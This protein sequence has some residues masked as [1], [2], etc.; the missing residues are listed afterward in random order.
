MAISKIPGAG[1]S[2]DT[3]E[4]GDI[5]D[6][7]IG[8]A[9]LANDVTISTS[10]NI[11][12]T[13]S[14][15]LSVAGTSTLTGNVTAAGTH[16][17]TGNAT[18][19]GTLGVTGNA[20]ASGNLTVTGDIIPS[21]PLSHRNMI[22]NGGMQIFQRATGATTATT[23]YDTADR[24]RLYDPSSGSYTSEKHTMS[25]AEL[26]T[27]GQ[28]H[29]LKLACTGVSSAGSGDHAYF[30]QPLEG[31]DCQRLLYGTANAKTVTLSFWVKSTITGTYCVSVYVDAASNYQVAKEYTISSADTWEKKTITIT[32]TEGSTSLIT[33]SGALFDDN[34]SQAFLL[35]FFL[36]S[37]SSIE[38]AANEWGTGG[39][40]YSTSGQVNWLSSTSNRFYI[41]GIQLEEGSSATPFEYR[42]FGEELTR[43]ERYHQRS[44]G[45]DWFA[46]GYNIKSNDNKRVLTSHD[47]KTEMRAT[48]T[49]TIS[50][51]GTAG[52]TFFDNWGVGNT[53]T[54]DG[55]YA[56]WRTRKHFTTGWTGTE[57]ANQP[58]NLIS[59][60][61]VADIEL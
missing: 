28:R 47:F 12:T 13:G 25:A 6:D 23:T 55:I 56:P 32:P 41:T 30:Y 11:A 45:D 39:T 27:T 16:A 4:A 58:H 57:T 19:G 35:Y 48:P 26:N 29:A 18:V 40:R 24:W 8:T 1:V 17:V 34:T 3:L 31:Q 15:T 44:E 38:G 36:V 46:L 61:W 43:C 52:N 22:Y 60:K 9:E 51:G 49:V 50:R 10:G 42:T 2:A 7:A 37:G 21:T 59:F 14:G 33:S 5:A 53:G 20:T 54:C